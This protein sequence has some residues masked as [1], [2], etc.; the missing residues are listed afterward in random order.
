[1]ILVN[2]SPFSDTPDVYQKLILLSLL[3]LGG[4]FAA[5]SAPAED[6]IWLFVW[7]SDEALTDGA[8]DWRALAQIFGE[9]VNT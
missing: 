9:R 3:R 4:T 6:D 2:N 7:T 1:V 5:I 8:F